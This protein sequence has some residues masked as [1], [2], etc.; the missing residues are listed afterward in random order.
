MEKIVKSFI[1]HSL[2]AE[3]IMNICNGETNLKTISDLKYVNNIDDILYPYGSCLILYNKSDGSPGHW[4]CIISHG[5]TLEFFCPYGFKPDEALK[6]IKNGPYLS[7]LM[8]NSRYNILYND[9]SLQEYKN[10]VNVY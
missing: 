9:V 8:K 5:D 10:N 2:S 6:Y 4:S 7:N 1:K 3:D